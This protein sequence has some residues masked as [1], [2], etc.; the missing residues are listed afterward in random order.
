MRA[1][2]AMSERRAG[3]HARS[4]VCDASMH[5]SIKPVNCI[6]EAPMMRLR[7][8]RRDHRWVFQS[9]SD[10]GSERLR[11]F[12]RDYQIEVFVGAFMF[13]MHRTEPCD[14]FAARCA[15]Q[16]TRALPWASAPF[17]AF[18]KRLTRFTSLMGSWCVSSERK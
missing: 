18:F 12:V 5:L 14:G 4:D 8:P 17:I 2:R 11:R 9:R 6:G 7:R 15:W 3:R 10:I 13:A 16:L 1:W